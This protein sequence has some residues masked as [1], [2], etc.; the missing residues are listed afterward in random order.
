MSSLEGELGVE[1]EA[2]KPTWMRRAPETF[3]RDREDLIS[4]Q[5]GCAI[6]SA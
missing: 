4:C 3:A 5:M 2:T 1:G 6:S